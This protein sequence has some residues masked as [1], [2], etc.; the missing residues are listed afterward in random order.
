VREAR[1]ESDQTRK[2]C[3][4]QTMPTARSPRAI[5]TITCHNRAP[6]PHAHVKVNTLLLICLLA[7]AQLINQVDPLRLRVIAACDEHRASLV[8]A[9]GQVGGRSRRQR[10]LGSHGS[11]HAPGL[12]LCHNL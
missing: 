10:H 11:Q 12:S 1:L 9:P 7:Q 5:R 8:S 4:H 3:R 2:V 6:S